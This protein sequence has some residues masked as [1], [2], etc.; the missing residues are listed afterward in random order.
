LIT[1]KKTPPYNK[2]ATATIIIPT[3]NQ[4]K[5]LQT[6]I[7]SIRAHTK[8]PY[9]IIVVNNASGLPTQNWIEEQEDI[10]EIRLAQNMGFTIPT[11]LGMEISDTPYTVLAN[12]DITVTHGWLKHLIECTKEDASTGIVGPISNKVSGPQ[13]D[14]TARYNSAQE[15]HKHASAI[16][17]QNR[18]MHEK[19]RRIVFFCT[20][21]KKEVIDKIGFLYEKFSPGNYEDDDYCLRAIKAGFTC[22]IDRSTFI[23]HYCSSSWKQNPQAYHQILERNRR[24]FTHK[25]GTTESNFLRSRS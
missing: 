17:E 16:R 10:L 23:H 13:L 9:K 2:A 8:T 25:W 15:L 24:Y 11:N 12:D 18:G 6:T 22:L 21:I 1:A 14:A 7:N 19:V 20:L 4:L 5:L 3:F